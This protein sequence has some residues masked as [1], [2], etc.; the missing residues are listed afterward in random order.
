[1]PNV[2]DALSLYF[3]WILSNP[4]FGFDL[5]INPKRLIR[6]WL[7]SELKKWNINVV[8]T[9]KKDELVRKLELTLAN[10]IEMTQNGK[11]RIL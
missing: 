11:K 1:M 9:A 10:K 4:H 6:E 7:L 3:S 8:N 5:S 2:S